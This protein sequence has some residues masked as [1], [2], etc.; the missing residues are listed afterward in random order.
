MWWVMWGKYGQ[1]TEVDDAGRGTRL[2]KCS[3]GSLNEAFVFGQTMVVISS[4]TNVEGLVEWN[5]IAHVSK[6]LAH[7]DHFNKDLHVIPTQLGNEH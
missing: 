3:H 7:E 5:C 6:G 4:H 1:P 2:P